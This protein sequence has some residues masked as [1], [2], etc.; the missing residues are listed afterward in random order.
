M[1]LSRRKGAETPFLIK[2]LRQKHPLELPNVGG[3][4]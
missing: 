4:P 2:V 3:P 1:E